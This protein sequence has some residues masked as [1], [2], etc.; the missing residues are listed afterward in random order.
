[1]QYFRVYVSYGVRIFCFILSFFCII[2]FLYAK[3]E[4]NAN[5]VKQPVANVSLESNLDSI[6]LKSSEIKIEDKPVM[7]VF[8]KD[9]CYHCNILSASLIG[10]ATIQGF[11]TLNFSP[12]Y[13]NISDTK[14][15]KIPYLSLSGISS[16]DM[17][18]L[19]KVNALPLIIFISTDSKEIMRVSGFPG[20]KRLIY[21]L[22]FINNDMWKNYATPKERVQAFLEYEQNKEKQNK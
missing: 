2:T 14:R 16:K 18:K 11:I 1:M 15:H 7:I 19:Y 20:E 6:F 22:E 21:L 17:A 13:I 9:D 3:D 8:G 12:Y 5:M 10:N 4:T